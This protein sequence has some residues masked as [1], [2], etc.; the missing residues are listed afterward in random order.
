MIVERLDIEIGPGLGRIKSILFRV[1]V[2]FDLSDVE[3]V[4]N[5]AG[6]LNGPEKMWP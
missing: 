5:A 3:S 6:D 4:W 2:E 1:Q